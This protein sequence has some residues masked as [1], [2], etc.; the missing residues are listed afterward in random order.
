M[1][2]L[3]FAL[4]WLLSFP[5]MAEEAPT[6]P[7]ILYAPENYLS[8]FPNEYFSIQ[9]R[10]PSYISEDIRIPGNNNFDLVVTRKLRFS[11]WLFN[12]YRIEIGLGL[13]VNQHV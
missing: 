3:N 5:L 11:T 12:R 2:L 6:K 4:L 10:T 13:I 1:K 9:T 8:D 7:Y